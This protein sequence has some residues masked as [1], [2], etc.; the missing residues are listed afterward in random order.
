VHTIGATLKPAPRIS[1]K[2]IEQHPGRRLNLHELLAANAYCNHIATMAN[3]SMTIRGV[4]DTVL[5]RLRAR[6]AR[7]H[8]SLNGE[9]LAIL[10]RAAEEGADD[11]GTGTVREVA[12]V[13]GRAGQ[14]ADGS[15]AGPASSASLLD[16]VDRAALAR[17]C[18][19]HHI[20]WLA[21]FGSHARGD[22]GPGSDIDVVVDFAPGMTPG[23]GIIRVADALRPVFGGRWVDLVTR[24]GLAPR[25]RD[26]ILSEA[27]VLH[28]A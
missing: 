15:A 17:V 25:L 12:A 11:P 9:V 10:A 26:R 8:R 4:P 28:A 6:A 18:R 23:L 16:A 24:R 21:V 3:R 14:A 22:A 5:A 13:Y 19:Q 7:Q 20:R 1:L 2:A 27:R